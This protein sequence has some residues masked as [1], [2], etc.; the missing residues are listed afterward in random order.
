M[1]DAKRRE[2]YFRNFVRS[3][4]LVLLVPLFSGLFIYVL[5]IGVIEEDAQATSLAI[6]EQNKAIVSQTLEE[7]DNVVS[8][9][10]FDQKVFSF[11]NMEPFLPG[12]P[13][14]GIV[15]EAYE[16]LN[17]FVVTSRLIRDIVIVA[18][19]SGL[20]ISKSIPFSNEAFFYGDLFRI[21]GIDAEDWERNILDTLH[22]RQYLP[23]AMVTLVNNDFN[24]IPYLQTLPIEF[25][26]PKLGLSMVLI[27]ADAI[28][29]MMRR[30][31]LEDDGSA[32]ILNKS[33]DMVAST[34][35]VPSGMNTLVSGLG[36]K[37]GSMRR[38]LDGREYL[39]VHTFSTLN[40]WTYGAAIPWKR[41]MAKANSI[42]LSI[43]IVFSLTL[44]V[45]IFI[46]LTVSARK[47][48]PLSAMLADNE[49]MKEKL[50]SQIPLVRSGFFRRLF[51]GNIG[52]ADNLEAMLRHLGLKHQPGRLTVAMIRYG[53]AQVLTATDPLERIDLSRLIIRES[54]EEAVPNEMYLYDVDEST[55]ACIFLFDTED[56][57]LCRIYLGK[58]L[59]ALDAKLKNDFNLTASAGI[60]GLV[61]S[62]ADLHHSYAEA[63]R[64]LE[65][66]R[67][68]QG[69]RFLWYS[70]IHEPAD[71]LF[72]PFETESRLVNLMK[73][74]KKPEALALLDKILDEN[75]EK[76][77][78]FGKTA[79]KLFNLILATCMRFM[80]Q[81]GTEADL[82][83]IEERTH[84]AFCFDSMLQCVQESIREACDRFVE[85]K[86]I[87]E[88]RLKDT[89]IAFVVESFHRSELCLAMVADK[90]GYSESYMY[91]LFMNKVGTS[92]SSFLEDV[93]IRK[94]KEYL[95]K[96]EVHIDDVAALCG[97]ASSHSFRRAFKRA[98]GM[99]PSEFRDM[100]FR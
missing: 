16:R 33:G 4:I 85:T 95:I 70:D 71:R 45:G 39:I 48:R 8:Q 2:T 54:V 58:T 17:S 55:Q 23:S 36:T 5:T 6:L 28:G 63:H 20:V 65:S 78:V 1:D 81:Y 12:T 34:G 89:V 43:W 79:E 21:H 29:E 88:V 73:L 82:M 61:G 52:S 86:A 7:I 62:W 27:D 56:E 32:F 15:K 46:L 100:S 64:A 97:Y 53:S 41:V 75:F 10:P 38:N 87:A 42:R 31:P 59:E 91:E 51:D 30:L 92:F 93:R 57:A 9:L 22:L 98:V 25:P 19:R 60:G 13:E 77:K 40:S 50:E 24:A 37:S 67:F 83:T 11:L 68:S 72:Y 96:A 44:G 3:Y 47:A 49:T 94:A 14:V 99:L 80:D 18:R 66:L 84:R 90:F 35:T 69:L 74:G 26:R 76:R